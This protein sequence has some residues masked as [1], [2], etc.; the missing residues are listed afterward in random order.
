LCAAFVRAG[1]DEGALR[2]IVREEATNAVKPMVDQVATYASAAA[3]H[4]F[5]YEC[6]SAGSQTSVRDDDFKANLAKF[7][8]LAKNTCMVL[9]KLPSHYV[10]GAPHLFV[11]YG[12]CLGVY[13][14][15]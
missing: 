11:S 13:P 5:R 12:K 9:S 6:A 10:I 14:S 3:R 2:R 15:V 4:R 8:K 1:I 7:Y